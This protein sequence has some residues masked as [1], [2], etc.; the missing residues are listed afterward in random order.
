MR[1]PA[2][3]PGVARVLPALAFYHLLLIAGAVLLLVGIELPKELLALGGG[4]LM[5]AGVAIQFAVIRWSMRQAEQAP[6]EGGRVTPTVA[7]EP[8][9]MLCTTC[10]W[11]G[12]ASSIFCP[13]CHRVLVRPFRG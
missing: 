10:G 12:S 8:R 5:I 6:S 4:A 9:P 3:T 2:K 11:E 1:A 7:I 13:R